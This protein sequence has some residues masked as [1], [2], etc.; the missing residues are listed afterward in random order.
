VREIEPEMQQIV[1]PIGYIERNSIHYIAI[2]I[3]VYLRF[4]YNEFIVG[5][6]VLLRNFPSAEYLVFVAEERIHTTQARY[7]STTLQ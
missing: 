1:V 6:Q 3:A 4:T 2:S 7:T 5:L